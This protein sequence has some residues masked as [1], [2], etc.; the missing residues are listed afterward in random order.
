MFKWR[1]VSRSNMNGK[2]HTFQKDFDD[3]DDSQK[4]IGDN[5]EYD[6]T[7]LFQNFWNPWGIWEDTLL[8]GRGSTLPSLPTDSRHLPEGADLEKYEKRRLE[9]RQTEAENV[10]KLQSLE[11]T[12]AYLSD[13]FEENPDDTE[14]KSDL[15]KIE[16]ELN[17]IG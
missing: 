1:I 10:M 3:Y 13:Y 12:K 4:F 8:T 5:P 6:S 15:E 14:A 16:T 17:S 2:I 9:K 11:R 7:R